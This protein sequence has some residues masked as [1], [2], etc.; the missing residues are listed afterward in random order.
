M[1]RLVLAALLSVAAALTV[2]TTAQAQGDLGGEVKDAPHRTGFWANAG[3]GWGSL[4]CSACSGR[5][6]GI[7]GS[8]VFGGT[9]S[10]GFLIGGGAAGWTKTVN[11]TALTIAIVD[12]RFRFYTTARSNFFIT[13]GAGLGRI[14][15]GVTGS[16]VAGEL[17]TGFVLG[18]GY[19]IRLGNAASLTPYIHFY[20]AKTENLDANVAQAGLSI[21]IH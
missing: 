8:V 21:T 17:G 1:K 6:T 9:L 2:A 14:G 3:A 4:G 15:D 19:D 11:D 20:G 16:G 5:T 13:V 10:A 7:S 18:V 12:A